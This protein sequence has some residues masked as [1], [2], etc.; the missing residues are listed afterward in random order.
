MFETKPMKF[1]LVLVAALAVLGLS[2]CILSPKEEVPDK[3][4]SVWKDLTQ[5][6][7]VIDNLV[8]AYKAHDINHYQDL[9]LLDDQSAFDPYIWYNQATDVG[10]P[11]E[12]LEV[13]TLLQDD[14]RETRGMFAAADRASGVPTSLYLDQLDLTLLP[15]SWLQIADFNG[16]P[17]ADCWE[18][19]REY[20]ITI[21]F[22]EE[23]KTVT[24]NDLVKFTVV[25]I[26]V[27]G[28]TYY[29]LARADDIMDPSK[30][31]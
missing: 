29:R 19:T 7:D 13:Y 3:P 31:H 17:C 4:P 9:L 11:P 10:P 14:V 25:G 2:G 1:A 18:T 16:I 15:G 24:G 21:H 27:N 26:P 23:D 28:K 30:P 22:V 5:K 8:Q 6:E 12:G 20:T